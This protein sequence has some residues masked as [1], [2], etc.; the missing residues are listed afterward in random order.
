MSYEEEDTCMSYKEEDTSMSSEEEDT[1]LLRHPL[2]SSF[3]VRRRLEQGCLGILLLIARE[4]AV[5]YLNRGGFA[6]RGVV[7]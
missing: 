5:S 1:Y 6:A 3:D 2:P 4:R 7:S